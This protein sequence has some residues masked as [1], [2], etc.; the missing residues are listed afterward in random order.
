MP[1]ADQAD[2]DGDGSGDVCDA[3]VD[4]DGQADLDEAACGS[5]PRDVGSVSPDV[6]GDG[7]LDCLDPDDDND[8]VA[9]ERDHCPGTVIPDPVIPTR[10]VLKVNRFALLDGD[11]IFDGNWNSHHFFSYTTQATGGCNATQ[12]ADALRLGKSYYEFGLPRGIL[13]I[14]ILLKSWIAPLP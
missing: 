1:N 10:G 7:L 14:W 13:V 8:G 9:D 3:D 4:G 11:L 12:I 2:L 5:D 6:D